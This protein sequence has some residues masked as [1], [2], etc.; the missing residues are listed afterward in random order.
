[1]NRAY[2][3]T[4]AAILFMGSSLWNPSASTA[5]TPAGQLQETWEQIVLILKSARFDSEP[6]IDAF[7]IK[8]MQ[9]IIPRFDFAEMAKRSLGAHWADRTAEEQEQY[10]K[11]FMAMLA[12][13]YIGGIREYKDSTVLYTRESND[14][15]RAE[16]DTKI[17]TKGAKDLFVSYRMHFVEENWKVYD[18]IID[19]VSLI[20]NYRAQ[21]H[22]VIA[23][24]SFEGLIR[25]MKERQQG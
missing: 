8:V 5:I 24:S 14:A 20:D 12:R 25:I 19:D 3:I 4:T 10:V 13:S 1:M 15:N 11:L 6:E 22:R 21:F 16:I 18:V 23:H 17:V 7:R 2:K 9:A